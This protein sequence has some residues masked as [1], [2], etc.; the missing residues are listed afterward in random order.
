MLNNCILDKGKE[1]QW[2]NPRDP[3]GNS[4]SPPKVV[5]MKD[6]TIPINDSIKI[7]A[8]GSGTSAGIAKYYWGFDSVSFLDSTDKNSIECAFS[9][10][11]NVLVF[12]KVRDS[13]RVFSNTDTVIID[14]QL[15]KPSIQVK[16][17]DTVFI[18]DSIKVL[19]TGIDSNGTILK[20]IWATN[21]PDFND[22]TVKGEL[23]VPFYERG[24]QS[25]FVT[26]QDDDGVFSDTAIINIFVREAIPVITS[27]NDTVC[28]INDSITVSASG[29][30]SNG[31]IEKYYWA[32]ND[33]NYLDSTSSGMFTAVFHSSGLNKILVKV[34]D[35]DNL[36][37][38][39]DTINVT[40]FQKAP[41]VTAQNDTICSINDSITVSASGYDSNGVIEKY[42]WEVKGGFTDSTNTGSFTTAFTDAGFYTI[43]IKVRDDD[44]IFSQLD[45]AVVEVDTDVPKPFSGKDTVVYKGKQVQLTGS[46][47]QDFGTITMYKW[48]FDGDFVYDD[49]STE[50]SSV[51]HWYEK[52]G[53]YYVH[54][55]VRDDDNNSAVDTMQITVTTFLP[56]I[57]ILSSDTT[58]SVNDTVL[59]TVA[60][61]D[62]DGNITEYAW[63]FNSD[64]SYEY[65]DSTSGITRHQYIT[66]SNYSS[67]IKITDSDSAVIFDTVMVSVLLDIPE[68][69][70]EADTQVKINSKI[71]F[72][73]RVN[74][75]FGFI[76]KYKWDFDGD[77]VYDDS[78]STDSIATY[79]YNHAGVYSVKYY[80]RDDDGNV[81]ID[82]RDVTVVNN[83][84]VINSIN[85][86]TT[87]SIN[88]TVYFY[89]KVFDNDGSIAEF[90]WDFNGGGIDYTDA[91]SGNTRFIYTSVGNFDAILKVTDDDNKSRLDTVAIQVIQD[92]PQIQAG[93]DTTVQINSNIILT[94][95]VTQG[96]GEFLLYKWDFDG[97]G[98]YDDSS[99]LSPSL[100]YT[101]I[102]EDVYIAK[103]YAIDDDSNVV[104]DER[105]VTVQN[106]API[107][108]DIRADTC[109]TIYDSIQ[110][111]ATVSDNEGTISEVAWDFDGNG[112][113]DFVT[114]DTV[115]SGYRYNSVGIYNAVLKV[116]DDD[117]KPAFDTV[118][119]KVSLAP[120]ILVPKSDTIVSQS[121]T[122]RFF[123][124]AT[125]SNTSGTL[126]KYFWDSG[127]DGWDDSTVTSYYDFFL[128]DGGSL[129]VVWGVRDDDNNISLDSFSIIFNKHPSAPVIHEPPD[130][131]F[132]V[133]Q[134]FS[135]SLSKG[136]VTFRF[137]SYDADGITDTLTN[138][139]FL[140]TDQDSMLLTYTGT[141]TSVLL[142]ALDTSATYYWKIISKDLFADSAITLGS[143]LT[144]SPYRCFNGKFMDTR[145][146]QQ[147]VCDT[148][149]TQI[150][151]LENL[152]FSPVS[153]NGW[154][155][156]DTSSTCE[157]YGRLYDWNTATG[158][159]HG[160]GQDVCPKNWHLPTKT[161]W[162]T[163][164]TAVGGNTV[165]GIR[166]K[167]TSWNGTDN[168]RF[169]A[170]PAGARHTSGEIWYFGSYGYF[171]TAT[172]NPSNPGSAWHFY[173]RTDSD[174]SYLSYIF[175][176]S[177]GNSVRCIQD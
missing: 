28:S 85:N 84:P 125:D 157:T 30:D 93:N 4:W 101:Y 74:Q 96:F 123:A 141:D 109:I 52:T 32:V 89:V 169:N 48:D 127:A 34:R 139:L 24:V 156:T 77:G 21:G 128:T 149:S 45:S 2:D 144:S 119:V 12:V 17:P 62:S 41:R 105:T 177:Y 111:S 55:Y 38:I 138:Y 104:T 151:M 9:T 43:L 158:D 146:T 42:Y 49:S 35:E 72:P 135:D 147:Y 81:D 58:I 18:Y 115:I 162:E 140:G 168:Y 153:G 166:L 145:D 67:I 70:A 10:S 5:A 129:P 6:T 170:L 82:G 83:A 134:S 121:D 124:M 78:S 172:I 150:W 36:F 14:V 94:G 69:A 40:V 107:I 11:N 176:L 68:I 25:V 142:E 173:L 132:A 159:V 63:D 126:V 65:I 26:T 95:S 50:S 114:V 71:V 75:L 174:E 15:C 27:K 165:A 76:E 106:H 161:E 66:A 1:P 99:T 46:V 167:S 61:S 86:D 64:G 19:A 103:F 8:E 110:F 98:V 116:K 130:S 73:T 91:S 56:Y 79:T 33:S 23:N 39:P 136:K 47:S 131:G 100:S 13:N 59:Y 3:S 171:I 60:A 53:T 148:V 57:T 163:L 154:C 16:A 118:I 88:D 44:G 122:V 29:Y 90:A 92:I 80:V 31:V 152:N 7:R 137:S 117:E 175:N 113:Y 155:S 143:F 87:I 97:D 160:N 51:T 20:Y 112:V 120:P 108:S 22:T 133:W 164:V 102:H 54:F 37:S